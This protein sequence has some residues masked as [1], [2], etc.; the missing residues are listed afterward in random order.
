M[1]KYEVFVTYS[2]D[3]TI[4]VDAADAEEALDMV[5]ESDDYHDLL[6]YS[7]NRGVTISWDDVNVYDVLEADNA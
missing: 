5:F 6:P 1:P 2:I 4:I 3:D 7:E